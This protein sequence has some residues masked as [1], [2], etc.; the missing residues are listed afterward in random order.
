MAFVSGL[1]PATRLYFGRE[2]S[3]SMTANQ[4]ASKYQA[5]DPPSPE[6]V[7]EGVVIR[8]DT[9]RENRIPP[10]QIRTSKWPVLQYAQVVDVSVDVWRL[11]VGDLVERPLSLAWDEFQSLPRIK[12][13]S[14]FHCVTQ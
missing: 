14:D 4:D 12:V 11:E 1:M 8:L 7:A 5:G 9:Q 10:G 13:F 3:T 6:D 2:R